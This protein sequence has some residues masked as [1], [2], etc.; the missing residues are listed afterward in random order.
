M[1]DCLKCITATLCVMIF[2]GV[3]VCGL[4]FG[5]L[6]LIP[7]SPF[8]EKHISWG[9][10][11]TVLSV[12]G[13]LGVVAIF[14]LLAALF[15]ICAPFMLVVLVVEKI[16]SCCDSSESERAQAAEPVVVAV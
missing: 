9:I 5:I 8:D 3:N 4:I 6:M 15:V 16:Q 12:T 7:S 10:V 1:G 14:G 13:I 11:L 2:V